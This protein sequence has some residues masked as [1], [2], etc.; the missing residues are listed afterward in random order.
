MKLPPELLALVATAPM[1]EGR[2]VGTPRH[3]ID[4]KVSPEWVAHELGRKFAGSIEGRLTVTADRLPNGDEV[5][6]ARSMVMN[7]FVFAELMFKAYDLGRG[8]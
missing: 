3:F 2:V 7:T 4:G 1:L 5:Y 8:A 6:T